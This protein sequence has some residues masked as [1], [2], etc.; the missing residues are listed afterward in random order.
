M[1][2]TQATPVMASSRPQYNTLVQYVVDNDPFLL[3]YLDTHVLELELNRHPSRHLIF[4]Y[5]GNARWPAREGLTKGKGKGYA[6]QKAAC[7]N[8]RSPLA[9]KITRVSPKKKKGRHLIVCS[10]ASRKSAS[11]EGGLAWYQPPRYGSSSCYAIAGSTANNQM[12]R[13]AL[14]Q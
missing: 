5:C 11:L 13:E 14:H 7:I 2:D 9:S 8:R 1:H 3:E 6:S 10:V 4:M 12:P